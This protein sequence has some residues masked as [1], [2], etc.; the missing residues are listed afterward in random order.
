MRDVR[1]GS[2]EG[3]DGHE[4]GRS[5]QVASRACSHGFCISVFKAT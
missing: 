2:R 4:Q 3:D 5:Q 1:E